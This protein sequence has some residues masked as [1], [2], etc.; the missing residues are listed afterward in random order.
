ME[1]ALHRGAIRSLPLTLALAS[2]VACS[3]SNATSNAHSVATYPPD[4]TEGCSALPVEKLFPI[5]GAFLGPAPGPC[6]TTDD[7]AHFLFRYDSNAVLVNQVSDD[8]AD[9]TEFTHEQG[10]LV[11]E[12]R[13]QPAGVTKTAYEYANNAIKTI[14]THPDNTTVAYEYQLDDRGYITTARLLNAVRSGSIPTH[15]SYEY[16]NCSIKWRVA[17]DRNDA[18]NLSETAEYVYDEQ[19]QLTKRTSQ[20]SE[21]L[22]D[23]SCW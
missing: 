9:T 3:S 23:Y 8:E 13:T 10:L 15:F 16:L 20:T 5:I 4:E 17:Y 14:T 21:V 19:G 12:T 7:N 6:T 18:V 2:V 22:F 1:Q 11:N